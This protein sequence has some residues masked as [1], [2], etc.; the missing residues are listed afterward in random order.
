MGLYSLG[1]ARA[2]SIG[3]FSASCGRAAAVSGVCD[4]DR[5]GLAPYF[6]RSLDRSSLDI[7]SCVACPAVFWEF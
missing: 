5:R 1:T 3:T 4:G 7:E 2:V 6:R